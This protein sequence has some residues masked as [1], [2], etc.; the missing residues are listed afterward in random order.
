[1]SSFLTAHQHIVCSTNANTESS[2][3]LMIKHGHRKYDKKI[4]PRVQMSPGNTWK[5]LEACAQWR[6]V[7]SGTPEAGTWQTPSENGTGL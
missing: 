5:T 7:C 4:L 2:I 1:V 6:T 3:K